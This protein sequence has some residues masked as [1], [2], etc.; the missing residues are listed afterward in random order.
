ML[1]TSLTACRPQRAEASAFPIAMQLQKLSRAVCPE[2]FASLSAVRKP[3]RSGLTMARAPFSQPS[4]NPFYCSLPVTTIPLS[5]YNGRQP[6][7]NAMDHKI[8]DWPHA[9]CRNIQVRASLACSQPP[10]MA[11]K[12]AS[13]HSRLHILF[14]AN[15]GILAFALALARMGGRH[16][17]VKRRCSVRLMSRLQRVKQ[18]YE[19]S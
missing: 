13:D 10:E 7:A 16:P 17:P 11:V 6:A 12:K 19:F 4:R 9:E 14:R 15:G 18:N 2:P 1:L 3:R 5:R 8:R